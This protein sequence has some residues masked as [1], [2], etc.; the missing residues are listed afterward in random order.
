MGEEGIA[1]AEILAGKDGHV[2]YNAI[3]GVIYTYPEIATVG[4]TEEELK[5]K[6]IKYTKGKFNFS[7]NSRARCNDDSEGLVKVL[8]DDK[9]TMLGC[10]IIGPNAGEMIAEAV[11]AIEYGASS[12]DIART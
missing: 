2:N 1:V 11:I 8:C 10:H 12:E 6:G 7:A 4:A 3:P 9:D 5:E